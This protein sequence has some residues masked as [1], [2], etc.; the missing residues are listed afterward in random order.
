MKKI[1]LGAGTDI[2]TDYINH[3]IAALKDIDVVHD[4]NQF[5]WPFKSNSAKEILALDILEHLNDF[6]K[7][8]EEIERIL[9]PN[10]KCKIKV[11]YWNSTS[12]Y[13]DPT[14]KRGFH[15]LTFSFFDP[16]K[17]YCKLRP[18]YTKA[19]FYISSEV[20]VL[21][22]FQPYFSVPFCSQI[23]I[24]NKILK[25][26]IGLIGNTLNNIILDLEIELTKI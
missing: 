25:K 1:N 21:S 9:E 20:F 4:L 15:E 19:R 16:N 14:H 13:I 8:M 2:R 24:K 6:I 10:G 12:A 11:P 26:I 22:L 7:S 23:R 17:S 3:D 5:P 18:Y